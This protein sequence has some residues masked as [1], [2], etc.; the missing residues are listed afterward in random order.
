MQAQAR[1]LGVARQLEFLGW[2]EKKEFSAALASCG[3]VIVP[4]ICFDSFPTIILEAMRAARPVI[5]TIYGGSR[6]AVEEEK[7]GFIRDPHDTESFAAAIAQVLKDKQLA[8]A[9]GKAGQER[10]RNYFAI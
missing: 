4:S 1:E 9:L 3:V 5:A 2:L 6:E 7:T 8:A 10:F